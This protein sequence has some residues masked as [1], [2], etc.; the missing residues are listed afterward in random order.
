MILGGI[1]FSGVVV[2]G[3]GLYFIWYH[4]GRDLPEEAHSPY[5]EA[6]I[7]AYGSDHD[8]GNI[9]AVQPFLS[10]RDY[11]SEQNFYQA[12]DHYLGLAQ[13]RG[14]L[15]SKTIVAFPEYIGTWLVAASEKQTV[16]NAATITQGMRPIVLCHLLPF[17][18]ELPF[19]AKNAQDTIKY[20]LFKVKAKSMAHIYHNV[21][22]QLAKEYQVT[23]VAGSII[24]P[25]PRLHQ[26]RLETGAGKLYNISVVYQP[27]GKPYPFLVWKAFPT[28]SESSF[29]AK[30]SPA[31]LPVFETPAGR[32]AVLICAD[33]WYPVSYQVLKALQVDY[34]ISPSYKPL[35][36]KFS[37]PWGG[38]DG[39]PAPDDVN[40][41]DIGKITEEE[42]LLK[43]SLPGRI[44]S[45]GVHLGV[46]VFLRG[47]FWDLGS[48]GYPILVD[49]E[50]TIPGNS[51]SGAV[52]FNFWLP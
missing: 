12:L 21:F 1:I 42:A 11:T 38:Y 9:L 35:D 7:S 18:K 43:Y 25:S 24:L 33:A 31:D 4:S 30:G 49:H 14:Y 16:Y 13:S 50:K 52:L 51:L 45:A 37:N 46:E 19:A 20:S 26:G 6:A 3:A 8:H 17:I 28:S 39:Y 22:S 29:I 32:L 44:S 36:S 41:G 34:I 10:M 27:D 2:I 48:D 15:N 47:D 23:I 5:P 40:L